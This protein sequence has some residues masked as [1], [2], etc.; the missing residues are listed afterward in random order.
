MILHTKKLAMVYMVKISSD[1]VRFVVGVSRHFSGF[2]ALFWRKKPKT[3]K[4][5]PESYFLPVLKPHS[6][7]QNTRTTPVGRMVTWGERETKIEK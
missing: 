2:W 6:K 7:F 1:F 5:P 4:L 3:K